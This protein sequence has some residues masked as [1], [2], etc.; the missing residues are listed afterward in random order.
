MAKIMQKLDKVGTDFFSS[1]KAHLKKI[2]LSYVMTEGNHSEV[3][4]TVWL[5]QTEWTVVVEFLHSSATLHFS[6]Y[7]GVY[8]KLTHSLCFL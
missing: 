7:L 8:C 3:F 4:Y 1:K 6:L 2:A 5:M